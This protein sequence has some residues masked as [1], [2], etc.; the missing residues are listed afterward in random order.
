MSVAFL[1]EKIVSISEV[2]PPRWKAPLIKHCKARSPGSRTRDDPEACF[3][4]S[5]NGGTGGAL[6]PMDC[7]SP[8]PTRIGSEMPSTEPEDEPSAGARRL[9]SSDRPSS[10]VVT[11]TAYV[12][13]AVS[14]EHGT[15][16]TKR[17]RTVVE[18]SIEGH[19]SRGLCTC[20][21]MSLTSR[22][23]LCPKLP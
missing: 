14:G 3:V 5:W 8:E 21:L 15:E 6:I 16:M 9:D 12:M 23:P 20:R 17:Q 7:A 1:L 2:S 11:D 10:S 13:W 4:P 18:A 19:G 22:A